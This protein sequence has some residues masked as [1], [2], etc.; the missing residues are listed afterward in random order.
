VITAIC[1]ECGKVFKA[2]VILGRVRCPQCRS[3]NVSVAI[4]IEKN[5]DSRAGSAGFGRT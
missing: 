3:E 4:A 5:V 1:N 2:M